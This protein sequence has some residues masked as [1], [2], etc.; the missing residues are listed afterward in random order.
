MP[1]ASKRASHEPP[2]SASHFGDS[3]SGYFSEKDLAIISGASSGAAD[4]KAQQQKRRANWEKMNLMNL[5]FT[6]EPG[7]SEPKL[8]VYD[9]GISF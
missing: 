1:L 7:M 5:F 6:I 3:I 9:M 2:D 4:A 8:G